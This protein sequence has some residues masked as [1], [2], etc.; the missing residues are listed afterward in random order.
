MFNDVDENGLWD[1]IVIAGGFGN[2]N[3]LSENEKALKM[4]KNHKANGKIYAAICASPALVY[5][6]GIIDKEQITCYPA[7]KDKIA[8]NWVD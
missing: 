3:A 1:V 8:D 5:T 4:I 7:L 6:K 2:A